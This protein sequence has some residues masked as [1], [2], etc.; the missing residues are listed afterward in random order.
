MT[1]ISRLQTGVALTVVLGLAMTDLASVVAAIPQLGPY[2]GRDMFWYGLAAL[3]LVY[4]VAVERRKLS[5]IGFVRPS[6][7]TLAIAVA[8]FVA[9]IVVTVAVFFLV[10]PML[11]LVDQETAAVESAAAAPYWSRVL[12]VIR[13]A[14]CEEIIFRGFAVERLQELSG[15]STV[16]AVVSGVIFTLGHLHSWGWQ[17]LI[18]VAIGAV[19]FTLL[20]VWRRNLWANILA[21]ALG[22]VLGF[23]LLG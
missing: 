5:S 3:V 12:R 14:T 6:W 19:G 11:H 10:F 9:I 21:H 16:A 17:H 15:S 23:R 4:V 8:T 20:Y 18:L 13:S 7:T 2:V 22:D 1:A